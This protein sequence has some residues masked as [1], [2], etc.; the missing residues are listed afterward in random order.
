MCSA[1]VR[2]VRQNRNLSAVP[3]ILS[4]RVLAGCNIE[5][6]TYS[7]SRIRP[8]GQK[9]CYDQGGSQRAEQ[10]SSRLAR[11]L[12]GRI[13]TGATTLVLSMDLSL[14]PCPWYGRLRGVHS[15]QLQLIQ[16]TCAHLA[17]DAV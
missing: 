2:V 17:Y 4:F 16:M 13:R 5:T 9:T 7:S 8:S 15:S 12:Y 10:V 6:P 3:D 14:V 1:P 11:L